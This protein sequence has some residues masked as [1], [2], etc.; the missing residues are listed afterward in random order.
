M[1][2]STVTSA[3][4]RIASLISAAA[5]RSVPAR[6]AGPGPGAR[7]CTRSMASQAAP[8]ARRSRRGSARAGR[9]PRRWPALAGSRQRCAQPQHHERPH[10]IRESDRRN[11]GRG[12]PPARTVVRLVPARY[13]DAS[14]GWRHQDCR[15]SRPRA[16]PE[17][18]VSVRGRPPAGVSPLRLVRVI[19]GRVPQVSGPGVSSG[20]SRPAFRRGRDVAQ[21]AG[22]DDPVPS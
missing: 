13:L 4:A 2:K 9:A 7:A 19:P 10:A 5:S 3:S 20:A 1:V 8:A 6:P 18:P 11:Q 22:E 12:A 21:A 14:A 17:H 16:R 15:N